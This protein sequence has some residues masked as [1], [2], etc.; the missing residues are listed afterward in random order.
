MTDAPER[1]WRV[2]PS[3][4]RGYVDGLASWPTAQDA[5]D[6]AT[7]YVRDDIYAALEADNARMREVLRPFAEYAKHYDP[8]EDDDADRCWVHEYTP[9]LD[10]LRRARAVLT[11]GTDHD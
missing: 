7:G 8:V 2:K 9:T 1:I 3:M 4:K 5:G 10:E 11:K 6:G